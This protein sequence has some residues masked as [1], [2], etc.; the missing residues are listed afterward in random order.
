MIYNVQIR[1][2]LCVVN[3]RVIEA[4]QLTAQIGCKVMQSIY[5]S[6]GLGTA[7]VLL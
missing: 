1:R 6:G 7:L 5:I 2:A 3:A 4:I